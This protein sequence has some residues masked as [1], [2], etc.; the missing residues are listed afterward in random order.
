MINGKVEA[1]RVFFVVN[2]W[3]Y[4]YDSGFNPAYSKY[5]IMQSLN[6]NIMTHL[7]QDPSITHIN[8]SVG[9]DENKMRWQPE[10]RIIYKLRMIPPNWKAAL[11][12]RLATLAGYLRNNPV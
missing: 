3:A 11:L 12:F 1:I 10:E 8:L 4:L 5:G 2:G 6:I 9:L 7:I